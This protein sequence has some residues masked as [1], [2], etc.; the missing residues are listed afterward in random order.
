M[1]QGPR[2]EILSKGEKMNQKQKLIPLQPWIRKQG[3]VADAMRKLIQMGVPC[4][5]QMCRNWSQ[6]Q[7]PNAFARIVLSIKG[8]SS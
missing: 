2:Q 8:F 6:G 5:Y 7:Q 1:P 4:D 3:S